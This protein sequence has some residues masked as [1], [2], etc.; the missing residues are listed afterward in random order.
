MTDLDR[1]FERVAKLVKELEIKKASKKKAEDIRSVESKYDVGKNVNPKQTEFTKALDELLSEAFPGNPSDEEDVDVHTEKELEQASP[2]TTVVS[3]AGEG[4]P[5]ADVYGAESGLEAT[6]DKLASLSDERLFQMYDEAVQEFLAGFMEDH[7]NKTAAA[8]TNVIKQAEYD[9][10]LVVGFLSGIKRA[11]EEEEKSEEEPKAEEKP[12]E[13][14]G[15]ADVPN[16]GGEGVMD[17][18]TAAAVLAQADPQEVV[19]AFNEVVS[20]DP[21]LKQAVEEVAEELSQAAPT[22]GEGAGAPT[23]GEIDPQT[24]AAILAQADPQ[25]V[26][27]AFNEVLQEDPDLRQA[28]EEVASELEGVVSEGGPEAIQKVKER[29]EEEPGLK[30]DLEQVLSETAQKLE[31]AASE[32]K[33]EEESPKEASFKISKAEPDVVANELDNALLELGVTPEEVERFT[34]N[35]KNKW[36]GTKIASVVNNF[37]NSKVYRIVKANG[38]RDPQLRERLKD[39]LYELMVQI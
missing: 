10:D 6:K 29:V 20:E 18:Q 5:G 26:D 34:K 39:Y 36:V 3:S 17:P 32:E 37:R 31:G 13:K 4:K 9:A 21:D 15:P 25:E 22:M 30:S 27:E 8:V 11:Q 1:T 28:V 7:L 16:A 24:A 23:G 12:D 38:K 35:N 2:A 14:R 19:A 33:E